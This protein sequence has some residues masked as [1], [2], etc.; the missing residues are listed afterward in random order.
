MGR[1]RK[2]T[3]KKSEEMRKKRQAPVV[4]S[5]VVQQE[6]AAENSLNRIRELNT[7][8]PMF[9]LPLLYLFLQMNTSL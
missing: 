1:K 5:A 3:A 4:S 9:Q 8:V 2:S 6:D 7:H